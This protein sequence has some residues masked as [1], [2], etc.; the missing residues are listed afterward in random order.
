MLR[1]GAHLIVQT[2]VM[3]ERIAARHG[4]AADRV[5][6]IAQ[7]APL[8]LASAANG[9]LHA[10]AI[11]A[12]HRP[13]RLLFLATPLAHKNHA[14]L[15]AVVRELRARGLARRVA[16]FVT[17]DAA[18]ATRTIAAEDAD[19]VHNLGKMR[20]DQVGAAYRASSALFLPTLLESYGL[21]FVEALALGRPILTSDRDFARWMCGDLALYFDPLD[22]RSIV[23]VIERHAAGDVPDDLAS[24]AAERLRQFPRDWSEVAD[25]FIGVLR[26]VAA[27]VP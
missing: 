10:P 12:V 13:I 25:R 9:E 4:V 19:V 8:D 23:D 20:R 18:A 21:P 24:R 2:P 17:L 15:S 7:P 22:A 11:D 1:S 27:R 14:V 26:D 16:I 5:R 3:A 6:W